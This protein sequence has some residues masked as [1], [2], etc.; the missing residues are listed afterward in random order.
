MHKKA[1]KT[2]QNSK[3][4]KHKKQNLPARIF[5]TALATIKFLSDTRFIIGF[6]SFSGTAGF[7]KAGSLLYLLAKK[8]NKNQ[9]K[10]KQK[11]KKQRKITPMNK[12]KG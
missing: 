9:P 4:K 11:S 6:S 1:K 2:P 7:L 10:T 12:N 3:I 5:S 8:V